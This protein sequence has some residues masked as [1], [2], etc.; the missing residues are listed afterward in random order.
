MKMASG[1]S[2]EYQLTSVQNE[3][4]IRKERPQG[5][6]LCHSILCAIQRHQVRFNPGISDCHLQDKYTVSD[7]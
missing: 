6:P 3:L 2:S 7:K 1:A 4:S 5:I